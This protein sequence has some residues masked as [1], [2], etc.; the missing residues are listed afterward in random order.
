VSDPLDLSGILYLNPR[1]KKAYKTDADFVLIDDNTPWLYLGKIE[2]D[3]DQATPWVNLQPYAP[4]KKFD[5]EDID[6]D[7]F[8]LYVINEANGGVFEINPGILNKPPTVT[9]HKWKYHADGY[10]LNSSFGI[11]ALA[12]VGDELYLG[13]ESPPLAFF[14]IDLK[15]GKYTGIEKRAVQLGSQ[16]SMRYRNGTYYVLDRD[17]RCIWE[18]KNL[19]GQDH[20]CLPLW[21]HTQKPELDYHTR[22][23][24]DQFRAKAGT[25]EALDI[26]KGT[27]YIGLDNNGRSLKSNRLERRPAILVLELKEKAPIA[28]KK[29]KEIN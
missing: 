14:K 23:T 19:S 24:Q 9:A 20:Y 4:N 27:F 29:T 10:E 18:T 5:L 21:E 22:R 6:A 17:R 8:S 3:L 13:K 25:A 28:V 11:E 2:G 1:L 7:G 16:T 26:Y 15:T 12:L